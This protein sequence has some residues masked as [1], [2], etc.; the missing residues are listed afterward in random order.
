MRGSLPSKV[1]G[2]ENPALEVHNKVEAGRRLDVGLLLR[3]VVA[4]AAATSGIQQHKF[5]FLDIRSHKSKKSICYLLP[6]DIFLRGSKLMLRYLNFKRVYRNQ[7]F[8]RSRGHFICRTENHDVIIIS[9]LES[10]Y[11]ADGNGKR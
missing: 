11:D 6:T 1:I 4:E 5:F 9:I 7:F 3:D 10:N 2:L 8:S